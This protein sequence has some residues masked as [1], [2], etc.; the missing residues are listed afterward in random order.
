MRAQICARLA[1]LGIV[2]DEAANERL[3]GEGA[4][5][6]PSSAVQVRVVHAREDVVVVRAVRIIL[7]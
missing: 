3:V 7:G 1:H 4:I 6:S 5:E 2:I